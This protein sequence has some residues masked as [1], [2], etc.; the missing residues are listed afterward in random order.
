MYYNTIYLYT[1]Y[2][3]R[4]LQYSCTFIGETLGHALNNTTYC[5]RP[6]QWFTAT[7][8]SQ[9]TNYTATSRWEKLTYTATSRWG[10][11]TYTAT[12]RC[13]NSPIQLL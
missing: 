1:Y 5:Y 3:T 10:K 12:S 7:Q 9:Q 4:I 2:N 11:L 13:G 8:S 6:A